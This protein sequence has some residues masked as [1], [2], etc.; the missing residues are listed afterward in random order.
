[1]IKESLSQKKDVSETKRELGDSSLLYKNNLIEFFVELKKAKSPV[2]LHNGLY[3]LLFI[4]NNFVKPLP[5]TLSQFMTS[6]FD[7]FPPIYDTK[8]IA[9]YHMKESISS[10]EYL[11][12]K[13]VRA[14][15]HNKN[16]GNYYISII[17]STSSIIQYITKTISKAQSEE[18]NN[19]NQ[20]IC[21]NFRTFGFCQDFDCNYSHDINLLLDSEEK[22]KNKKKKEKKKYRKKQK[23]KEYRRGL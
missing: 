17:D 9:E 4:Y 19:S 11:F 14:N 12:Y 22:K 7:F 20:M 3:D 16:D 2:I 6:I 21:T 8:Y 1:L 10:L 23:D 5:E 15:V 18:P 13:S